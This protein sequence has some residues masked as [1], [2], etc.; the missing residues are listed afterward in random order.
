[1]PNS[2]NADPLGS[3]QVPEQEEDFLEPWNDDE[4]DGS[5]PN[6]SAFD[7]FDSSRMGDARLA[8]ETS[9]LDG[10]DTATIFA[11]GPQSRSLFSSEGNNA[12]D[13][14]KVLVFRISARKLEMWPVVVWSGQSRFLQA[15]YSSL[16]KL[17]LLRDGKS[18][19]TVPQSLEDL[20][21]TLSD[22]PMGFLKQPQFGIGLKKDYS[23]ILRSIAQFQDIE[24]VVMPASDVVSTSGSVY[25]LGTQRFEALRRAVD[26][27]RRRYRKEATEDIGLLAYTN[28]LTEVDESKYPVR[29]KAVKP[30]AL[31]ELVKLGGGER[32]TSDDRKAALSVVKAESK[33]LAK[34]DPIELLKLKTEIEIVTLDELIKKFEGMLSKKLSEPKWQEFFDANPFILSLV[35]AYPIFKLRGHASV[36][37]MK[38]D[39]S[40]E[41]ITDFLFRN[42]Q[43]G[44]LALIEIKRPD[45][46]LLWTQKSYRGGVFRPDGELCGAVTQ[47][48]D[49][50]FQLQ[51]DFA[52]KAYKSKLLNTHPYAIHCI[53]VAGMTPETDD[54]RK[55]FELFRNSSKD[56]SIVTFDETLEKL[57][58][59]R[60]VMGSGK[61]DD[62]SV[63]F[64]PSE[65][66]D[67][68]F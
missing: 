65:T 22:L 14:V 33:E 63:S 57:R 32:R 28:L 47:V 51:I 42:I 30:N 64:T 59:V 25:T 53:V 16:Q 27:I 7:G 1:M 23:Q 19:W 5:G 40:G 48:L 43:T 50:R 39:G 24:E 2:E 56:V 29:K 52:A 3:A 49:Q 10:L 18:Q 61:L 6:E 35:F 55:S 36:G 60:R 20:E 44:N 12:P 21:A 26:G 38:V 4:V 37:G 15:K 31:F 67:I 68:P 45:T 62:D 13:S 9:T 41:K 54:E 58:E 11:S 46:P 8:L 66:D 17:T 34:T